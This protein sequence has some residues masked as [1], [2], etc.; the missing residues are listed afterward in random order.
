MERSVGEGLMLIIRPQSRPMSLHEDQPD[1]AS[2]RSDLD[3]WHNPPH[4]P[5]WAACRLQAGRRQNRSSGAILG[6]KAIRAAPEWREGSRPLRQGERPLERY[7]S[8]KTA[9]RD[10]FCLMFLLPTRRKPSR[11]PPV[12]ILAYGSLPVW[13]YGP[14]PSWQ[15]ITIPRRRRRLGTPLALSGGFPY[16]APAFD[17]VSA[18]FHTRG[19][20]FEQSKSHPVTGDRR[21]ASWRHQPV[22]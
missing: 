9:P 3:R 11:G 21:K 5:A 13:A 15:A 20:R 16:I 18:R 1:V 10:G 17:C 4:H 7:S 8:K 19:G 12:A 2:V 14:L 6:E 22:N